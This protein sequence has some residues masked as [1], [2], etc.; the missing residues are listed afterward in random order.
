MRVRVFVCVRVLAAWENE[1][2]SAPLSS[3]SFS[4]SSF[5][6][7]PLSLSVSLSLFLYLDPPSLPPVSE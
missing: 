5:L 3:S 1:D 2:P 6:F 4:L 7:P